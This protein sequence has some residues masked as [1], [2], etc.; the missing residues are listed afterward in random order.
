MHFGTCPKQVLEMEAVVL[1]RVGILAY[2]C[3][4]QGQDFKPSAAPPYPNMRQ[5]PP[6]PHPRSYFIPPNEFSGSETHDSTR[7]WLKRHFELCYFQ[8]SQT[9]ITFLLSKSYFARLGG[10]SYVLIHEGANAEDFSPLCAKTTI[11]YTTVIKTNLSK[12]CP[13]AT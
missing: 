7:R 1:H 4:K 9:I 10:W 13:S 5:V 6:H 8:G 11:P 3:P 12:F 2:F